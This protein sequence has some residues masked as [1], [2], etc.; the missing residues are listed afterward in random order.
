MPTSSTV[1]LGL[2][3]RCWTAALRP[4]AK[5]Q[6]KMKSY[7]G[8]YSSYARSTCLFSNATSTF[9]PPETWI[10]GR[11]TNPEG[12]LPD[13]FYS[14][15][16]AVAKG[17]VRLEQEAHQQGGQAQEREKSTDVGERGDDHARG[18]RRIDPER[19][20]RDGDQGADHRRHDHVEHQ[21][22]AQDEG[23]QPAPLP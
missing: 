19:L 9:V 18:N 8:A 3:P 16:R 13:E 6:S 23:Q 22:E 1:S 10:G 7:T 15:A 17:L 21:G 5:T 11:S 14:P 2:R 20:E 4:G 12:R